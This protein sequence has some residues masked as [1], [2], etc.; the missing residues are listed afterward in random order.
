[1]RAFLKRRWFLLSCA[2][3]LLACTM[4]DV[5]RWSID[6]WS[7]DYG[8]ENGCLHYRSSKVYHFGNP[9]DSPPESGVVARFHLPRLGIFGYS[10][11]PKNYLSVTV[12]LW[13]PLS[14]VIGWIVIFEARWRKKGA[15]SAKAPGTN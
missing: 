6:S 4:I 13:I 3:A 10:S 15:I 1:M 11:L 8:V 14:G 7:R 5:F 9:E 12:P 2:I